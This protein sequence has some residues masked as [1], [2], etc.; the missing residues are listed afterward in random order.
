MKNSFLII[1]AFLTIETISCKYSTQ[2]ANRDDTVVHEVY[3]PQSGDQVEACYRTSKIYWKGTKPGGEH[4]GILNIKDGSRFIVEDGKLVGGSFIIDMTTLKDLDLVDEKLN[5]KLV[6]H[7]KSTDF[8]SVDS[9]PES[10]F[11]ITHVD[12]ISGDGMFN[13]L[14]NGN[15]TM[16]TTTLP[17]QF[18]ARVQIN[19]DKVTAVSDDIILD[20]TNWGII[21]QSKSIFSEL[22][23]KFIDDNFI[24]TIEIYSK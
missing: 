4:K 18:K 9:F 2:E 22:K 3:N 23:D 14:I 8:F 13:A 12:E 19:K 24:V 5:E 1:I 17:I 21:Y 7:L 20:R 6:K 10:T 16:K 15:L 11:V